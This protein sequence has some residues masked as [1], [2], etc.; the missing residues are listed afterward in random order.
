MYCVAVGDHTG[1]L[2]FKNTPE[3]TSFAAIS[4]EETADTPDTYS[5]VPVK[6]IDDIVSHDTPIF[7]F[8]TDTQ[9]FEL[10]VLRGARNILS[11]R[12]PLFLLVE[13]SFG[14]LQR[15]GVDPLD[16]LEY[17]YDFGYICTYMAYHTRMISQETNPKYS[18]VESSPMIHVDEYSVSF[19]E[20]IE[21]LRIVDVPGS[22][23]TSGWTDLLCTKL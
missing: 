6:R 7:L 17:I 11:G 10:S 15:A 8:K 20:F 21:S 13:F 16:V 1:T 22:A 3:S 19:V 12:G 14:L 4:S 23:K 9:G 2:T 18:I 5:R